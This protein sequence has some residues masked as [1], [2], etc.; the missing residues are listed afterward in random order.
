MLNQRLTQQQLLILRQTALQHQQQQLQQQKQQQQQQVS[1]P[2]SG[3][4]PQHQIQLQ[5]QVTSQNNQT[6]PVHLTAQV[7]TTQATPQTQPTL[8]L[9]AKIQ[10]PGIE[11]LR[12]TIALSTQRV[13]GALVRA[14]LP[15][16]SMQTEEV[17]ALLRQQQALRVAMQTKLAQQQQ[18]Q[19]QLAQQTHQIPQPKLSETLAM[20]S[21]TQ[22]V[23][24]QPSIVTPVESVKPPEQLSVDAS[25]LKVE[26][27]ERSQNP[28]QI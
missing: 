23:H 24:K 5:R 16:R 3:S 21:V 2:T 22:Q 28:K 4:Q 7:Q 20:T 1:L 9:P 14:G 26:L 15:G 13:Q 18:Q 19:Q 17:L 12:P 10:I 6:Q 11:Q 27:I 8:Q 25:Q